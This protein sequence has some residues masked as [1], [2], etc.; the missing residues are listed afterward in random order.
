M[1]AFNWII[2][3]D[4]DHPNLSVGRLR[5]QTHTAANYEGDQTGRF[6]DREYHLGEKMAWWP[7][8]DPRYLTWKERDSRID[9]PP[10]VDE[11]NE[12]IECCYAQNDDGEW[13]HYVVIR[14]Q[15]LVPIEV[16]DIGEEVNW[17]ESHFA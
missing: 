12:A 1:G 4:E 15:N 9:I 8:D 13:G 11:P 10:N 5:C 7:E 3:N 17:P 6:H 14:F 2:I 16:L